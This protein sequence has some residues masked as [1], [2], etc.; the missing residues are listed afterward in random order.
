[1]SKYATGVPGLSDILT[2]LALLE[3]QV[4]RHEEELATCL[5]QTL[6]PVG[7]PACGDISAVERLVKSEQLYRQGQEL[8]YGERHVVR[9]YWRG[10]SLLRESA[11]LGHADSVFALGLYLEDGEVYPESLE[12]S[13]RYYERSAL[14]CNSFGQSKYGFCLQFGLGFEKNQAEAVKYFKLSADQGTPSGQWQYGQCCLFGVGI[15]KSQ[16]EAVKYYKLSADQGNRSGQWRYAQCLE[17]GEGI[18]KSVAEAARYY[19]LA[20]D[21]GDRAAQAGYARCCRG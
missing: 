12:E 20:A 17:K 8:L 1:M 3:E 11:S 2:R 6:T 10:L 21:Q 16:A 18:Q 15:E 7:A 5:S 9:D 13:N 14:Q 4:R 19:K